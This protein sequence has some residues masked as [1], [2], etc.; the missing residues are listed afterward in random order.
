[1]LRLSLAVSGDGMGAKL[2][3]ADFDQEEWKAQIAGPTGL[4]GEERL[5]AFLAS[6][7]IARHCIRGEVL[8][9]H[10]HELLLARRVDLELTQLHEV[11]RHSDVLG[12]QHDCRARFHLTNPQR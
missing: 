10:V 4:D 7:G 1:M 3:I 12:A 2:R 8:R 5:R 6:Q 9:R 11:R